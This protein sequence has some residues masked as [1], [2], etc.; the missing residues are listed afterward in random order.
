MVHNTID[1]HFKM[2]SG[3]ADPEVLRRMIQNLFDSEWRT[4]GVYELE[5]KYKKC[6]KSFI[7]FEIFRQAHWKEY[8]PTQTEYRFKYELDGFK[9]SGIVDLWGEEDSIMIDWKTSKDTK[10][11]VSHL[12]QAEIYRRSKPNVKTV[13]FVC[14]GS[15]S[16]LT[17]PA[18]PPTWLT[19]QTQVFADAIKSGVFERKRQWCRSCEEVWACEFNDVYLWGDHPW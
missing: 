2:F 4:S 8:K 6:V 1:K 16:I 11:N 5:S 14:L 12:R 7:D 10:L 19:E 13:I 18:M 17:A 15:G 3:S 9:Y